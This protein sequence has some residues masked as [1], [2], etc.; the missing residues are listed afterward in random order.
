[1]LYSIIPNGSISFS[2]FSDSNQYFLSFCKLLNNCSTESFALPSVNE[3]STL[4]D[5]FQVEA[6]IR[7]LSVNM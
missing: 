3:L 6:E 4:S 2:V 5:E 7:G 1:L